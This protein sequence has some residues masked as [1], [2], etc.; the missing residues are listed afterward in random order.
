M[1]QGN[2]CFLF[3]SQSGETK[4][5][6]KMSSRDN[7]NEHV[8]I[9]RNEKSKGTSDMLSKS[10]QQHFSF[11]QKSSKKCGQ[12]QK[13]KFDAPESPKKINSEWRLNFAHLSAD[14]LKHFLSLDTQSTCD[15]FCNDALLDSVKQTE[16]NITIISNGGEINV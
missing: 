11:Y 9:K 10:A 2:R 14:D 5:L 8:K 7:K 12:N 1:L 4:Q 13:S 3:D 15:I 16:K 6:K